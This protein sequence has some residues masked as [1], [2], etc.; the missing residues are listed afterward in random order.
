[1][2]RSTG[3]LEPPDLDLISSICSLR[4]PTLSAIARARIRQSLRVFADVSAQVVVEIIAKEPQHSRLSNALIIQHSFDLAFHVSTCPHPPFDDG[5][6]QLVIR[7]DVT[8]RVIDGQPQ[9]P[10]LKHD[11]SIVVRRTIFGQLRTKER[12]PIQED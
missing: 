9:L 1:M 10:I 12:V 8:K 7:L 11:A 2:A 4:S 5:R 3:A 6:L